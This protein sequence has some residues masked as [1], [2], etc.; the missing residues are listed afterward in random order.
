[1]VQGI[2]DNVNIFEPERD[3]LDRA[4]EGYE[5]NVPLVGQIAAGFTPPGM[6]M[7][8][9]A[10][11]K[12]GRQGVRDFRSGLQNLGSVFGMRKAPSQLSS[13]AKN[14]G[15][16]ALSALGAIPLVGEFMKGPK[17]LLKGMDVSKADEIVDIKNINRAKD[18]SG[19]VMKSETKRVKQATELLKKSS[20]GTSY[21]GITQ[22]KRQPIE[23]LKNTDGTFTQ[24]GGKSTLEA[25]EAGGVKRIPV[26]IFDNAQDYNTYDFIRKNNKNIL[27]ES[28]ANKL[29]PT[30]GNP[31]FEGPVREF[32]NKTE[33]QFKLTFNKHQEG[34]TSAPQMFERAKRLNPEFQQQV[35]RV[36]DD[37][38]VNQGFNPVGGK[39]TGEID[40]LTGFPVGEVK[41][42]PRMIEKVNQKY[43]GDFSQITDPI[44]TRIVV[45]T[46]QQEKLI[47]ERIAKMFPTV[48][49]ER[50]LMKKSGYLDRKVNVQFTGANGENIIGEIGIITRP[51]L[52]GA[53]EAHNI[54]ETF[55]KTN[56]G[57][58]TGSSVAAIEKEGFRLEKQ[59]KDIFEPKGKLIDPRFY[60]DIIERFNRG[61]YV[62]AGR[63]GR[64]SP[65]TP[66][67][68]SNSDFDNLEPSMKKSFT[69]SGVASLQPPS[70]LSTG[71][72]NPKRLS[73][74]P[75]MTAAD[76]SQEKYVV[77]IPQSLQENAQTYNDDIFIELEEADYE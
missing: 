41:L 59:M 46:P 58:P 44:R 25:L 32:G 64:L 40:E 10:A 37:L 29:L 14:I 24:L 18:T 69:W 22:S 67:M 30:K 3:I 33:Q 51:M 49:G 54:Y 12:Y 53:H 76:L 60:D 50:V 75:T 28:D 39:I 38:G 57:L 62:N 5:E 42:M 63:S 45:E 4:V 9:A 55:R 1:M 74:L 71:K 6:A 15:I 36:A 21:K 47:A 19:N 20:A 27:R 26:K 35:A 73:S 11:G 61:G 34:I 70:S 2:S 72:K 52:D 48:D 7:D 43:S 65:I 31:T 13:G 16:A 68:F 77:S 23:V 8:L 17:N 66:N 56:F